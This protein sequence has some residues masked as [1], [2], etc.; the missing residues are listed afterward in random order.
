MRVR[1]VSV[2]VRRVRDA[3]AARRPAHLARQIQPDCAAHSCFVSHP[4]L[5]M[6]GM[7]KSVSCVSDEKSVSIPPA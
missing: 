2:L 7:R 4:N 3:Y 6:K 5:P 1:F